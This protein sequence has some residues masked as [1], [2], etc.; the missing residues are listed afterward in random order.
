[1]CIGSARIAETSFADLPFVHKHPPP[2]RAFATAC[3]PDGAIATAHPAGRTFAIACL[4]ESARETNATA[5][6]GTACGC[7]H[8]REGATASAYFPERASANSSS[9]SAERKLACWVGATA[10]NVGAN[11]GAHCGGA[12][13][14][15]LKLG[16]A[17]K[18]CNYCHMRRRIH[19]CWIG[20]K[21]ARAERHPPMM[22]AEAI[23]EKSS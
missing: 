1:M 21:L 22:L 6:A 16:R 18:S 4:G 20:L 17:D 13:W 11:V 19:A 12:C 2:P 8:C 15:G 14:I 7:T 23:H 5:S 9:A 3:C 10:A